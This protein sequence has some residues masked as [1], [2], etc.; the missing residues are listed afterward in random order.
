MHI[1]LLVTCGVLLRLL[2]TFQVSETLLK[3]NY[4]LHPLLKSFTK[5]NDL[6]LMCDCEIF[7][8]HLVK[9]AM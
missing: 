3:V 2:V 7:R 1:I 6:P 5:F 8:L 9:T 4:I